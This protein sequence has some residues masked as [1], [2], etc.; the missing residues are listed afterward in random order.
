MIKQIEKSPNDPREYFTYQIP[1]NKLNVFIVHDKSA[2]ISCVGMHVKVGYIY[3]P[4]PGCA[5]FCEHMLFN[6][7]EKYPDENDFMDY[8]KKN[9]GYANAFTS[10]NHTFYHYNVSSTFLLRSLDKFGQ[11]FIAPLM[12]KDSV[13]REKD[14][15]DSEHR[16]NI[17][18]DMW[19]LRDVLR[20]GCMKNHPF[21]KFGTGSRKSLNV[22]NIDKIVKNFYETYYSSDNMILFVITNNMDKLNDTINDIFKDVPIRAEPEQLKYNKIFDSP[23]T[24]KVVPINDMH[25]MTLNWEISS[26]YTLPVR[27]PNNFLS[28]ILGHEAINSIHHILTKLKYILSLV[29]GPMRTL[30]ETSIYSI[31][32]ELSPLGFENKGK[33]IKVIF[34][35]IKM[36]KESIGNKHLEDLYN[37]FKEQCKHKFEYL[38]K[39]SPEN[40]CMEFD[41][42]VSNMRIPIEH[43]PRIAYVYDEYANIKDNLFKVLGQMNTENVVVVIGAKEF[44]TENLQEDENYG[45]KFTTTSKIDI[46]KNFSAGELRLIPINKYV[47]LEKYI[48][49]ENYEIPKKIQLNNNVN[50]FYHPSNKYK[51]PNVCVNIEISMP[52]ALKNNKFFTE[53]VLCVRAILL[54]INNEKYLCQ[55]A[56]YSFDL[57]C[58]N[59]NI[60]IAIAGNRG[61]INQV[62]QFIINSILNYRQIS[63]NSFER[64]RFEM[65]MAVTNAINN[66]P[67]SRLTSYFS[68]KMCEKYY[69]NFDRLQVIDIISYEDMIKSLSIAIESS[70]V[71]VLVSGNVSLNLA[72]EI[73]NMLIPF[74]TNKNIDN[75]FVMNLY[76]IPIKNEIL[77]YPVENDHE[78]NSAMKYLLYI[79]SIAYGTTHNWN[80][81]ICLLKL[82]NSKLSSA[83][84]DSLRTKEKFG[85]IVDGNIESYG[86]L[87]FSS[88]YYVFT[89]QSPGKKPQEIINRTNEFILNFKNVLVEMTDNEFSEIVNGCISSVSEDYNNMSEESSHNMTQISNGF[90]SFN[91]KKVFAETLKKLKKEELVAF[92]DKK[93]INRNSIVVCFEGNT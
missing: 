38:D 48:E 62:V 54:E 77:I 3:D 9:G 82:L 43:L 36:L 89:V 2:T 46:D 91:I 44:T 47:S 67:Y 7:T 90:F 75:E 51:T 17:H 85:Y 64:A 70:S 20:H 29:A 93:F 10:H 26:F 52:N 32:M 61:K 42:I 30:G 74:S 31:E 71:N 34:D 40:T 59:E 15:V 65:K 19:R 1:K 5:H 41:S 79:D 80:K 63:R 76:K 72:I 83:Y 73:G 14:A 87:L 57:L 16:N 35:Y 55:S 4:I 45:T 8:V 60:C 18:N 11:F 27:S 81:T 58:E 56:H 66:P 84:F 39:E 68:K 22:P 13:D 24:I 50:L 53:V 33:I 69:D 21:N 23:K 37:E 86:N 88:I 92:Y 25:T 28:C 12:K 49:V 78:K 6:G